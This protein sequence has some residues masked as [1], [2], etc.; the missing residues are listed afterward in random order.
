[1]VEAQGLVKL[2]PLPDC[3]E[4]YECNGDMLNAGVRL[5]NQFIGCYY[6]PHIRLLGDFGSNLYL[7]TKQI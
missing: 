3:V 4:R 1:V 5:N 6:N 7:I 2:Y